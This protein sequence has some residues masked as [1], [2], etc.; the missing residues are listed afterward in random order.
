MFILDKHPIFFYIFNILPHTSDLDHQKN[1]SKNIDQHKC[2]SK[3]NPNPNMINSYLPYL[4]MKYTYLDSH[5]IQRFHL[6]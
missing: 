2:Y 1:S 5:D 3:D 4:Y 6:G